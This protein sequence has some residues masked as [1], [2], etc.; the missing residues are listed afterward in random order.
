MRAIIHSLRLRR[1]GRG[2]RCSHVSSQK[3]LN[4]RV[5]ALPLVL[6]EVA[7]ATAGNRDELV[8][9]TGLLQRLLKAH[10]VAVGH[11]RSGDA[12]FAMSAR[13]GWLPSH[14]TVY[15]QVSG[16]GFLFGPSSRSPMSAM[17]KKFT[18]AATWGSPGTR[19]DR[20]NPALAGTRPVVSA[21]CPPADAPATIS[22]LVSKS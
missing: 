21:R 20:S 1:A 12:A 4:R 16:N 18:I 15:G 22:L 14:C 11:Q 17:P 3:H 13:L 10:R 2:L 9:H 8:R 5:R 7:V 19:Q 6:R